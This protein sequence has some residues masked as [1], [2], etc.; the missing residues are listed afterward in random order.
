VYGYTFQLT[1]PIIYQLPTQTKHISYKSEHSF[2]NTMILWAT[3]GISLTTF[4]VSMM[5]DVICC[6]FHRNI[7]GVW[8]VTVPVAGALSAATVAVIRE[9]ALWKSC[10]YGGTSPC[11][12]NLGTDSVTD[13]GPSLVNRPQCPLP[14]W[15]SEPFWKWWQISLTLNPSHCNDWTVGSIT[16]L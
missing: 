3:N 6:Y 14:G 9:F 10:R 7:V 8:L 15:S 2:H 5:G 11:L 13:H 4:Y 12:L 1:I 16:L